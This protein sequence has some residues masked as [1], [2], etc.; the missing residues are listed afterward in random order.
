MSQPPVTLER[1]RTSV[2]GGFFGQV[3]KGE[4]VSCSDGVCEVQVPVGPH[5]QQYAGFVFG[6]IV[7]FIA[8]VAGAWACASQTGPNVTSQMNIHFLA[9]AKGELLLARAR[10][11]R[12]GRN[13]SVAQSEVF[14]LRHGVEREVALATVTAAPLEPRPA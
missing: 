14:V 8:D 12:L 1:L 2:S 3:L 4:V 6:G 9:P 5:I 7:G 10:V 11:V 13:L